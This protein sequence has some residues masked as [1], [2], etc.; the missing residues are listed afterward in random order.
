MIKYKSP[1]KE[2]EEEKDRVDWTPRIITGGKEP[3]DDEGKCWLEK[4]PI[5]NVFIARDKTNPSDYLGRLFRVASKLENTVVL[6]TP[7]HPSPLYAIPHI[8]CRKWM[9]H[10]DLGQMIMKEEEEND[11][12]RIQPDNGEQGSVVE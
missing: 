11:S 12:D 3:P 1:Q 9:M 7:E 8:F 5:G 4:L 6:N 2:E 10:E